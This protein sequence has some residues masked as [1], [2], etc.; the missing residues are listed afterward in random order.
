MGFKIQPIGWG[1]GKMYRCKKIGHE[2]I[3]GKAE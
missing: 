3:T 2:L 1:S